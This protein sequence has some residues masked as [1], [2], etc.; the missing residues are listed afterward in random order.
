[1]GDREVLIDPE[2]ER[3]RETFNDILQELAE[4]DA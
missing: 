2:I 1:M 4:V 3:I